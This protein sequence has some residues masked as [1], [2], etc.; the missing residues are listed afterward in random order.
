MQPL[1]ISVVQIS[2]SSKS[3]ILHLWYTAKQV[4]KDQEKNV[5]ID[6]VFNSSSKYSFHRNRHTSPQPSSLYFLSGYNHWILNNNNHQH[7]KCFQSL[8][9]V[10]Y[11]AIK[12]K[13]FHY[14]Y[15]T[16]HELNKPRRI[17]RASS[18]LLASYFPHDFPY[19]ERQLEP[20]RHLR[21]AKT[22]L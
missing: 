15:F 14:R 9:V 17:T 8:L 1:K 21:I 20:Q 6:F 2:P 11:A 16:H 5:R 3:F 18:E 19:P 7:Y 4:W 10:Y 22:D 13:F 12:I